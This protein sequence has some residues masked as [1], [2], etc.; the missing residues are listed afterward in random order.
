MMC[1][2][3]PLCGMTHPCQKAS[4]PPRHSSMH[5]AVPLHGPATA[6]GSGVSPQELS[7]P[8]CSPLPG[9]GP[10]HGRT[11]QRPQHTQHPIVLPT[12]RKGSLAI[13]KKQHPSSLSGKGHPQS[14]VP[15]P[16]AKKSPGPPRAPCL[17]GGVRRVCPC[18]TLGVPNQG[19]PPPKPSWT[20]AWRDGRFRS[21]RSAGARTKA[22]PGG[23]HTHG[24][25]SSARAHLKKHPL[26][27]QLSRLLLKRKD[28]S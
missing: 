24:P 19:D 25:R 2:A 17:W 8:F 11:W 10:Q 18:K 4:S 27:M 5:P 14:P 22:H 28:F 15:H 21:R 9:G 20:L 16:S 26:A 1:T 13:L 7:T 23:G 6:L 12:G 3:H